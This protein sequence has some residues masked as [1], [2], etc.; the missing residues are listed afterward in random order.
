[1]TKM[2]MSKYSKPYLGM[3]FFAISL[4][5]VQAYADLSLPSY[6]GNIVNIGIQQGGIENA[7]PL[8]INS[9]EMDRVVLFMNNVNRTYVFGNYTLINNFSADYNSYLQKYPVLQNISIYVLKDVNQSVIDQLNPVMAKSI[10]TTYFLEELYENQS[11]AINL[12]TNFTIL[13]HSAKTEQQFF[14]ILEILPTAILTTIMSIIDQ[15]FNSFGESMLIQAA[16]SPISNIY[17][18]LGMDTNKIQMD[19]MFNI[20]GIMVLLTLLS[21]SCYDYCWLLWI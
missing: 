14:D 5:F 10:L 13:L 8:A 19:Y 9:T 17:K 21:M 7:M 6:L 15:K 2:R 18:A 4:L 11:I 1:M 16:I 12:D 20:G 3:L